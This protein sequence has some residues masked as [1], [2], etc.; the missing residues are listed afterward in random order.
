MCLPTL[1]KG[2]YDVTR[3]FA[4]MLQSNPDAWRAAYQYERPDKSAWNG[5]RGA[6]L[7]QGFLEEKDLTGKKKKRGF[8]FLYELL[9]GDVG[10]RG[11]GARFFSGARAG[12]GFGVAAATSEVPSCGSSPHRRHVAGTGVACMR[13]PR[14]AGGGHSEPRPCASVCG[15]WRAV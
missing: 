9:R 8:F 6:S 13:L 2:A 10:S 4:Q 14:S 3:D 12:G 15:G 7:A 1:T 11:C 5:Y